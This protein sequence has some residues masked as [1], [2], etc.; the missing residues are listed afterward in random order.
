MPLKYA[1]VQHPESVTLSYYLG[2]AVSQ[3]SPQLKPLMN[4]E[5]Y[6]RSGVPCSLP[7]INRLPFELDLGP[8]PVTLSYKIIE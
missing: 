2:T 4:H 6:L 3:I 5:Q 8:V 7:N 1:S